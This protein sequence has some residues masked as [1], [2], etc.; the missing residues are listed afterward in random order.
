MANPTI[1]KQTVEMDEVS[2]REFSKIRKMNIAAFV[3]FA[4]VAALFGG[5][6][7]RDYRP[8]VKGIPTDTY[9]IRRTVSIDPKTQNGQVLIEARKFTNHTEWLLF[10][11]VVAFMV[12]TSLGHLIVSTIGRKMYEEDL[13]EQGYNRF[14]WIEYSI[15]SAIM[16]VVLAFS[17]GCQELWALVALVVTNVVMMYCGFVAECN[18]APGSVNVRRALL[19][20][21]MGTLLFVF[22]WAYLWVGFDNTLS[23]L[24]DIRKQFDGRE[25]DGQLPNSFFQAL[26]FGLFFLYFSF[27]GVQAFHLFK[28]NNVYSTK[29]NADEKSKEDRSKSIRR[30]VEVGYITLSFVSK[31]LLAS[32]LIWGLSGR[33][34]AS[35][36]RKDDKNSSYPQLIQ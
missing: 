6:V 22:I 33:N 7:G 1:P 24:E 28:I 5:L 36:K 29:N 18:M 8:D 16:L 12:I 14:R 21:G 4:F 19:A 20:W 9:V 34:Q 17:L 3:L 23:D 15:T 27:G 13:S 32:L 30:G 26:C 25:N 31:T 2:T 10:W 35:A 11:L